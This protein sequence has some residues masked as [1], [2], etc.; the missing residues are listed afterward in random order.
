M[1]KGN[2]YSEQNVL[3]VSLTEISYGSVTMLI[4]PQFC[5]TSIFIF[6]QMKEKT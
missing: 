3:S 1:N 4:N 2:F 5:H 6:R